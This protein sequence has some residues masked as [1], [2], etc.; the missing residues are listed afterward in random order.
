MLEGNLSVI[1][2][3]SPV[4]EA[5]NESNLDVA[6]CLDAVRGDDQAAARDLVEHLYPLVI[7]IVRGHLPRR[8]DEEDLAQ[9]VFMKLFA[10]LEDYRGTAP[11]EH[12]VSRIA[13][14]TCLN[15]LRAEK[16]RPELRWADLSPEQAAVLAAL[17]GSSDDSHPMDAKI[18][19]EV[20]T[21]LLEC[22]PPRDRMIIQML[23]LD[24]LPVAEISRRTGWPQTLIRVRAFRARRRLRRSLDAIQTSKT[25]KART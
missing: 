12:W 16:C 4:S 24:D 13:L 21:E 5:G 17:P 6:A 23:E 14:N 22:L 11:F 7:K 9:E 15:Q 19:H 20:V 2:S 25:N 3:F 8:L 1:S 10:K 18:S